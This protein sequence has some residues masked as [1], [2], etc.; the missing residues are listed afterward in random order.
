[1]ISYKKEDYDKLQK[2]KEE[3]EKKNEEIILDLEDCL[4]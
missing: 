4:L 2:Q 1:M 3:K